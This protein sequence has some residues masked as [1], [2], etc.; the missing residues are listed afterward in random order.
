MLSQRGCSPYIVLYVYSVI[1]QHF[2]SPRLSPP[3]STPLAVVEYRQRNIV[4]MSNVDWDSKLVIGS[5]A[6]TATVTKKSS[7][8]NGVLITLRLH[9]RTTC[10]SSHSCMFSQVILVPGNVS[11]IRVIR[12]VGQAM[13]WQRTRRPRVV[14]IRPAKVCTSSP[15]CVAYNP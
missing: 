5:K 1:Q 10:L 11:L 2:Y 4:K 12:L 15:V 13:S 6:R 7:D 3:S 14:P 9:V 8:L